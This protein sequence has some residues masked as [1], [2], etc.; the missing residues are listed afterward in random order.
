[1]VAKILEDWVEPDTFL[2]LGVA[3]LK[4]YQ[5]ELAKEQLTSIKILQWSI[6]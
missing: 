3:F 5:Y 1:M 2:N 6:G 4:N